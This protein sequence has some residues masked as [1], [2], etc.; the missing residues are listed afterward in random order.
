MM[1]KIPTTRYVDSDSEDDNEYSD[2][3]E[4]GLDDEKTD[5][6]EEN[7]ENPDDPESVKQLDEVIVI[8]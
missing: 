5:D 6:I 7:L 4:E 3:D 8:D 2:D 1:M